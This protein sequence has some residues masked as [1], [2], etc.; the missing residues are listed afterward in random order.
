MIDNL[1]VS[2]THLDGTCSKH[3]RKGTMLGNTYYA[4]SKWINEQ[5]GVSDSYQAPEALLKILYNKEVRE[6]VF[7]NFLM[8]YEGDVSYDWFTLYFQ[9]EHADRKNKK[10][11]FTPNSVAKLLSELT[12]GNDCN[13]SLIYD[14]PAG[15][16]GLLI[17]K[18][19]HERVKSNP[20]D[21][22]PGWYLHVAEDLSSRAMPFSLFNVMVRGMNVVVAHCD[23]I[24]RETYGVF[25]VQND[26]DDHMTFSNLNLM[27]CPEGTPKK[28][29]VPKNWRD[30]EGSN[31][32]GVPHHYVK[33]LYE[34]I[35]ESTGPDGD[36]VPSYVADALSNDS[37]YSTP[38]ADFLD[39]AF[40][41]AGR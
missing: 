23:V 11:D 18:W 29:E 6:Q 28:N 35:V 21:Y 15:T 14:A 41:I 38:F 24:T 12:S 33:Q 36:S 37:Y 34:P 25:F 22:K 9:E 5:L 26:K 10:Q 27:P 1:K 16:G 7:R 32:V 20:L 40:K 30:V 19:D 8:E 31:L 13:N 4:D 3:Y 39:V 17:N 2:P